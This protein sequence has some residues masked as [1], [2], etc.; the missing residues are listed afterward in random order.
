MNTTN[1]IST[2]LTKSLH[3]L[4]WEFNHHFYTASN[5]KCIFHSILLFV[6][7]P[8]RETE[9][10]YFFPFSIHVGLSPFCI[11]KTEHLRLGNSERKEM[12]FLQF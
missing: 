9:L 10:F 8:H 1:Q 6:K 11:A 2:T 5:E 3:W 4:F 7:L 12:Y